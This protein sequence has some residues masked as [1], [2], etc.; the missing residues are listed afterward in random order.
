M[1]AAWDRIES[2]W[3]SYIRRNNSRSFCYALEVPLYLMKEAISAVVNNERSG[4]EKLLL[5]T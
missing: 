5:H 2:S 4:S 1:I 3:C